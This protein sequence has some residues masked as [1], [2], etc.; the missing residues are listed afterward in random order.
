MH[1]SASVAALV[2]MHWL[3][4]YTPIVPAADPPVFLRGDANADG[5]VSTSD[6]FFLWRFPEC[7][8]NKDQ[9]PP[10]CMDAADANDDGKLNISDAVHVLTWVV[11]GEPPVEPF[12][13]PGPDP[14][15]GDPLG[16]ESYEVTPAA[17]ADQLIRIGDVTAVPG[18][19]VQVPFYLT[20]SVDIE[21]VQLFVKYD[22]M[23]FTLAFGRK[24][25]FDGTPWAGAYERGATRGVRAFPTEEFIAIAACGDNSFNEAYWIPPGPE[26]LLLKLRGMIAPDTAP[27]TT[28]TLELTDGQYG[29]GVLP[30]L[31]LRN[32][33]THR[34]QAR[35]PILTPETPAGR[36]A[37][38]DD[39][40]FF[41]RGD[42]NDD[43]LVDIS[44]AVFVLAHLFLGSPAPRCA[45][46]ADADDSGSLDLTDAIVVMDSL[47]LGGTRIA[48]PH[49]R[50]G[51]DSTADR[52]ARCPPLSRP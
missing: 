33:L 6:A 25:V 19:E 36:I 17:G 14:T 30:P 10:A 45:D 4:L 8:A 43:R 20:N 34:G 9:P 50:P 35:F 1:R 26:K 37:I 52:L 32:E 51:T 29:Q 5:K 44:D 12:P 21:A 28:I 38:V 7:P 46:A 27:G 15:G 41:L 22:P 2:G 16:C 23:V 42:G 39:V 48:E 13:L 49:P 18:E 3:S 11:L 40:S 31:N 47:F 24:L